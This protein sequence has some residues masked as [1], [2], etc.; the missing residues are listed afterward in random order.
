ML[1]NLRR[2]SLTGWI[3]IAIVLG[4]A[5]G[6]AFPEPAQHLQIASNI[7]LRLIKCIIVPLLFS[8]LVVGIAGHSEDL[9]SVGRLALKSILYFEAVTTLVSLVIGFWI[10][11]EHDLF[12]NLALE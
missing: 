12:P 5:I 10:A 7:F 11:V 9:K 1:A 3:I 8:T 6:V 2:I 4:I